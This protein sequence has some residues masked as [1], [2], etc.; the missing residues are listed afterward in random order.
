M[1]WP[2]EITLLSADAVLRETLYARHIFCRL[3]DPD[4]S[5]VIASQSMIAFAIYGGNGDRCLF[6]ATKRNE[7]GEYAVVDAFH[8]TPDEWPSSVIADSFIEWLEKMLD[9]V[10]IHGQFLAYWLPQKI[11]ETPWGGLVRCKR[12]RGAARYVPET[13]ISPTRNDGETMA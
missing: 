3:G 5:E 2:H 10:A 13:V 1:A 8:E 9:S 6:N 12:L 4:P 11:R 7:R